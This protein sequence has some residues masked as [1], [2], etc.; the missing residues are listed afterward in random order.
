MSPIT[1]HYAISLDDGS[2][3]DNTQDG[4]P[5]EIALGD[6]SLHPALERCLRDLEPGERASF[7]LS[8]EEGF[9]AYDP[10]LVQTLDRA[11]FADRA[12][13][14][15]GTLLAFDTPS[16]DELAGRVLAVDGDRVTVDFNH[17]LAGR[18]ITFSV[19]VLARD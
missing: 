17:P 7:H 9:G 13:L 2:V 16:G 19:Y 4:E 6:G 3:V 12:M 15:P 11:D 5:L 10:E 8:A 1:L 14:E 18:S